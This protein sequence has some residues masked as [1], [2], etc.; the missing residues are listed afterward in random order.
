MNSHQPPF[1]SHLNLALWICSGKEHSHTQIIV[2]WE[3]FKHV[4]TVVCQYMTPKSRDKKKSH[5]RQKS[6]QNVRH[7]ACW[8]RK[9]WGQVGVGLQQP[10]LLMIRFVC[11]NKCSHNPV[12]QR[13]ECMQMS[14]ETDVEVVPLNL[15]NETGECPDSRCFQISRDVVLTVLTRRRR[16]R[17][18]RRRRQAFQN[19]VYTR[20]RYGCT[21]PGRV[22]VLSGSRKSDMIGQAPQDSTVDSCI[23]ARSWWSCTIWSRDGANGFHDISELWSFWKTRPPNDTIWLCTTVASQRDLW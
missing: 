9:I 21:S 3:M 19:R 20:F 2:I 8:S 11:V 13:V 4:Q 23:S 10:I 6:H 5:C 16:R 1:D 15:L 12:I 7:K 17:G 22:D 18:R 14:Q